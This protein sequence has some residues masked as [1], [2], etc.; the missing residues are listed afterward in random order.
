MG[1]LGTVVMGAPGGGGA[2]GG[3]AGIV[4]ARAG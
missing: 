4:K 1:F 3:G 2:G